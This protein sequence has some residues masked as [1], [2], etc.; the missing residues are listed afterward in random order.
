MILYK[1]TDGLLESEPAL[2]TFSI[3]E[4]TRPDDG[5][6]IPNGGV[7]Q[8]VDLVEDT[9]VE[10]TMISFNGDPLAT[11]ANFPSTAFDYDSVNGISI[12]CISTDDCEYSDYQ[13]F[14]TRDED[15]EAGY[16]NECFKINQYP[17]KMSQHKLTNTM[18]TTLEAILSP[19]GK[20]KR[21]PTI[22]NRT[23]NS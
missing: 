9:Q 7:S 3:Y 22:D 20:T 10:T 6:P 4:C 1:V 23:V 18:D 11:D 14:C 13:D 16:D 19:L 21:T 5:R 15:F 8:N 17:E 2:I 12:A